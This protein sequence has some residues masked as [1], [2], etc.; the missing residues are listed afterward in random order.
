MNGI[1]PDRFDPYKAMADAALPI[2]VPVE[3]AK[4]W[5][6]TALRYVF[7]GL[8]P[9]GG[10]LFL[11]LSYNAP[12]GSFPQSVYL[13]LSSGFA[14]FWA[15]PY[16]LQLGRSHRWLVPIAGIC[17]AAALFYFAKSSA[18]FNQSVLIE[19]SIAVLILVGLELTMTP[20]LNAIAAKQKELRAN[21]DALR[22]RLD[23]LT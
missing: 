1:D 13:E 3:R 23:E 6:F 9:I 8:F 19:F 14:F 15:A 10:A 16:V 21:Y 12:S 2:A 4:T 18:G 11:A 22:A 17:I 5:M 20:W 7:S